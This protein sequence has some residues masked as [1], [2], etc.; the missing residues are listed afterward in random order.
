MDLSSHLPSDLRQLSR[1]VIDLKQPYY[2]MGPLEELFRVLGGPR[3]RVLMVVGLGYPER[4]PGGPGVLGSPKAKVS[5][6]RDRVKCT[7]RLG[8]LGS[9]R[10]WGGPLTSLGLAV[11]GDRGGRDRVESNGDVVE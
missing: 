9:P 10:V 1:R 5:K 4:L 8:Q 11:D 2:R 7:V 3:A 6:E